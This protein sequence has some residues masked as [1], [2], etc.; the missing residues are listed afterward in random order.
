MLYYLV[1]Y[2]ARQQR[3][4]LLPDHCAHEPAWAQ[5]TLTQDRYSQ[6]LTDIKPNVANGYYV[7][8]GEFC[9]PSLHSLL[10]TQL[11]VSDYILVPP[12]HAP[13]LALRIHTPI[14]CENKG[15]ETTIPHLTSQ[16]APSISLVSSL[17]NLPSPGA[18]LDEVPPSGAPPKIRGSVMVAM[19]ESKEAVLEK[20][21]QDVYVK[22]CSHVS[23]LPPSH[24]NSFPGRSCCRVAESWP[25]RY[26]CAL[27]DTR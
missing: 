18:M 26:E 1:L 11:V 3:R 20:L 21:K 24:I 19:A 12:Y 15:R 10:Q 27:V 25:Y 7:F 22:V 2:L 16:L 4:M 17:T 8:G 14:G 9:Y 5:S 6:H 13:S 23:M